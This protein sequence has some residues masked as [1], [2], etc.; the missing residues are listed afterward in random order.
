MNDC[1]GVASSLPVQGVLFLDD[2][3]C[4]VIVVVLSTKR[5]MGRDYHIFCTIAPSM[6]FYLTTSIALISI[7]YQ[8]C[9]KDG[10]YFY[11][12]F[13][14]AGIGDSVTWI[15]KKAPNFKNFW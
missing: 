15:M 8:L 10:L 12:V 14:D 7:I 5:A 13:E 4:L 6:P 1:K 3:L 2:V 11:E 9:A